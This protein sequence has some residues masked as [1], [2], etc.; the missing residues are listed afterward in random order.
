MGSTP[1]GMTPNDIIMIDMTR[2]RSSSGAMVWTAVLL[3]DMNSI[4]P[5]LLAAMKTIA[6]QKTPIAPKAARNPAMMNA[7]TNMMR[8]LFGR[9]SKL[10]ETI[11]P[12]SPPTPPAPISS[13]KPRPPGRLNT[14]SAKSGSITCTGKA[15]NG[16]SIP[17]TRSMRMTGVE[18]A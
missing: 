3:E 14:S 7:P 16:I 9:P 18:T 15:K 1:M 17:A 6:T 12:M 4:C 11:V 5:T 2:P 10:A 8:P 13:P